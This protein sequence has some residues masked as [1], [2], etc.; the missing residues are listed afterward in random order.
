M[1]LPGVLLISWLSMPASAATLAFDAGSTQDAI[2]SADGYHVARFESAGTQDHWLV[3][4]RVRVRAAAGTLPAV[5]ALSADASQLLHLITVSGPDGSPAGV[6]IALNGRRVGTPYPE[7][8][9]LALSPNSRNAAYIAKTP[10]GWAVVSGQGVGPTFPEPPGSLVVSNSGTSYVAAWQGTSWLYR[11]HKP[12]RA[13]AGPEATFSGDLSRVGLVVRDSGQTFVE[14]DG[15]RYGP[16]VRASSPVFSRNGRH[17]A[18]LVVKP[19]ATDATYD[20]ILADG[21]MKVAALYGESSLLVDDDGRAFQVVILMAVDDKTQIRDVYLDGKE[22]RKS[23]RPPRVGMLAGGKHFVYPMMTPRGGVVGF[24]G[25]D[26]ETDA[27]IPLAYTPVEFDGAE[28]Y[29]Y[30]GLVGNTLRLVCG[31]TDGRDPKRTRCADKARRV[32]TPAE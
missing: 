32:F 1:I 6:A 22:L 25:R 5:A 26:L 3:D 27:P 7:I 29:H 16:Y 9:S 4:G 2:F 11:D 14:V 15:V 8:Q 18:S 13:L 30:W 17:W 23:G 31:A 10:G 20:G 21:R 24:D 19:G 28:E 12:V